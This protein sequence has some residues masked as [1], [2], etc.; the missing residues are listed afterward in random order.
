MHGQVVFHNTLLDVVGVNVEN[1]EDH[2][3]DYL[4]VIH[5]IKEHH[6]FLTLIHIFFWG[7]GSTQ[8]F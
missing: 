3:D 5:A 4:I 2:S 8:P 1:Y 6:V 7:G